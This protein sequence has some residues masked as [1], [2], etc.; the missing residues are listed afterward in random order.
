MAK[1]DSQPAQPASWSDTQG[2]TLSAFTADPEL[3]A[4][5]GEAGGSELVDEDTAGAKPDELE[6]PE[7]DEEQNQ[8]AE[9]ET[10]EEEGEE[11]EVETKGEGEEETAEEMKTLKFGEREIKLSA[12]D[13]HEVE[14]ATMR[15][16]DYTRAKQELSQKEQ[17]YGQ[18]AEQMRADY[19]KRI[20]E[21]YAE[22]GPEPQVDWQKLR[23][24]DP[25]AYLMQ[26]E[27]SRER[28]AKREKLRSEF[29]RTQS[30]Q[31]ES[32][33]RSLAQYVSEQS[34]KLFEK[35]PEWRDDAKR[36]SEGKDINDYLVWRG[37]TAEEIGQLYDH[38]HV[39]I[40][41][42]AM[43]YR[44]IKQQKTAVESKVRKLAPVIPQRVAKP[45]AKG[46]D[47][48]IKRASKSGRQRDALA[49]F[50]ALEN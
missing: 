5:I 37:F 16:D 24:E 22:I 12:E 29:Q 33:R 4:A 1:N 50:T 14:R 10:T 35:V 32:Q 46:F 19:G 9:E 38:R 31:M 3:L 47:S 39:L 25:H 36:I 7:K 26:R 41:R 48:L 2:S 45:E 11:E 27:Q 17:Q 18:F 21:L 40:A 30:E 43:R 28:E 6:T 20:A 23:D 49:V 34:Q 8:D 42:D 15:L 44:A 13:A